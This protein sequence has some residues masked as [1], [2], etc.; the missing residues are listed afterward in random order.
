ML[1]RNERPGDEDAIHSLTLSAFEPMAFSDG[2]EAPIIRSLRASGDLTLSLVAEKD[3]AIL[4]HIALSPVTIDGIHNNWFGLGPVSVRPE[5]QRRG[6]GRAL[7]LTGLEMLKERGAR[8]CALIGSPDIYSRVGFES[9]GQL[10]YGNL[11]RS[12]VQWIV[13]SGPAPRGELKFA[14][15]FEPEGHTSQHT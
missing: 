4:G 7:I 10:S 1:I 5:M 2:S 12:Y 6:I 9:D 11:D 14:P 15:A 13:F 8:G 3:G